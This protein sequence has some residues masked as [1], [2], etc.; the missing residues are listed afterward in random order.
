MGN[1]FVLQAYSPK[2]LNYHVPIWM[3]WVVGMA[4]CELFVQMSDLSLRYLMLVLK[5]VQVKGEL[6]DI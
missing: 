3:L 4:P 2:A 6:W 1:P 5:T